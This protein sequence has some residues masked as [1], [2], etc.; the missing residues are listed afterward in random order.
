[1]AAFSAAPK[2]R[3]WRSAAGLRPEPQG[4][5]TLAAGAASQEIG[6]G[7]R[8]LEACTKSVFSRHS[9]QSLIAAR[10]SREP[11]EFKTLSVDGAV[12][13]FTGVVYTTSSGSGQVHEYSR[14]ALY[15]ALSGIQARGVELA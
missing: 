12:Y 11:Q 10:P 2:S 3:P 9:T 14:C 4:A 1:M 7:A 6:V 5:R 15:T 13:G 8:I